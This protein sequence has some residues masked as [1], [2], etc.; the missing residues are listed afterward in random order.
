METFFY[1]DPRNEIDKS[2]KKISRLWSLIITLLVMSFCTI[3]IYFLIVNRTS[4]LT[5]GLGTI[6]KKV[7][8][9]NSVLVSNSTTLSNIEIN[10]NETNNK[11]DSLMSDISTVLNFS[12]KG[13]KTMNRIEKKADTLI[14]LINK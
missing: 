4:R 14:L 1:G 2:Q 5:K 9:T 6:E 11:I 10:Q 13:S 8:T 3:I 7:D 12:G